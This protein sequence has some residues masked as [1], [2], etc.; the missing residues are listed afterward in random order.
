MNTETI[1]LDIEGAE[2]T[3]KYVT[4]DCLSGGTYGGAGLPGKG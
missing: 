3:V 2:I 4:H 1:T